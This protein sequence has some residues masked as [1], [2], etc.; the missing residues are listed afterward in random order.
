MGSHLHLE[1]HTLLFM[2]TLF[3]KGSSQKE[4]DLEL[5]LIQITLLTLWNPKAFFLDIFLM[6]S[7]LS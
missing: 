1:L 6:R 4:F 3:K 2:H 5:N 7:S